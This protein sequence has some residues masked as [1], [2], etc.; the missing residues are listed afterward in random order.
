MLGESTGQVRFGEG[1]GRCLSRGHALDA[2]PKAG[3]TAA[4]SLGGT[5]AWRPGGGGWAWGGAVW[6]RCQREA[7]SREPVAAGPAGPFLNPLSVHENTE[8]ET[9]QQAAVQ[10]RWD[11]GTRRK[12]L[13]AGIF[14]GQACFSVWDG[15][16]NEVKGFITSPFWA[17]HPIGR[18]KSHSNVLSMID[19]Q[20]C[21]SLHKGTDSHSYLQNPTET[22]SPKLSG[23]VLASFSKKLVTAEKY[24]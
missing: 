1:R 21:R 8:E 24:F 5:P 4:G 13:S 3:H 7:E 12:Q 23:L 15:D 18:L 9:L 14:P 19:V 22:P 10:G 6:G 16:A 20:P 2:P 11:G 17:K